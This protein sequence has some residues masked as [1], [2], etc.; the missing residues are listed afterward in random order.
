L[1]G[2]GPLEG[3]ASEFTS[4][5]QFLFALLGLVSATHK[6]DRLLTRH[7]A[8]PAAPRLDPRHHFLLMTLGAVRLGQTLRAHVSTWAQEAPPAAH[9]A[10]E[11]E[12]WLRDMLL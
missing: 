12:P 5:N 8:S 1:S 6:L 4:R 9:S 10:P 7:A 3:H 2:A 11:R